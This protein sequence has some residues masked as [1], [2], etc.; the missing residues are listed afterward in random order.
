[1][2]VSA[3]RDRRW[4]P[5]VRLMLG[6]LEQVRAQAVEPPSPGAGEPWPSGGAGEHAPEGAADSHSDYEIVLGRPQIASWMFAG[7]IDRK[8]VV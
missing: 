7:V 8:S 5:I 2:C 3:Y 6:L 1:M 4:R